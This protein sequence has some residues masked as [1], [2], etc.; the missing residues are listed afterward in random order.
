MSLDFSILEAD[1]M[2]SVD[3]VSLGEYN[4]HIL[5]TVASEHSCRLLSKLQDYYGDAAF[6]PDEV[7][8][9]I[10]ELRIVQDDVKSEPIVLKDI[11]KIMGLFT[12]ALDGGKGVIA[13]AD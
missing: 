12:K 9:V 8:Q 13:L 3:Y 6:S 1:G 5:I 10:S 2:P 11:L 7:A 4:H